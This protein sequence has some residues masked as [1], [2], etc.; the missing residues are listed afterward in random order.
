MKKL[1]ILFISISSFSCNRE[2]FLDRQDE[3]LLGNWEVRRVS[4]TSNNRII[5]KNVTDEFQDFSVEF[6]DGNIMKWKTD[7]NLFS[8]SYQLFYYNDIYT[9]ENGSEQSLRLEAN[10]TDNN[11][12]EKS[13]VLE[14]VSVTQQRLRFNH[15]EEGVSNEFV[16]KR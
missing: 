13:I 5:S 3:K 2:A 9:G 1:I 15:R 16:M 7:N 8:G 6:L 11:A 14:S 4:Q 10:L 12:N